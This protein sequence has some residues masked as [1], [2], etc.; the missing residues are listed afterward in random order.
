MRR[1]VAALKWPYNDTA[2]VNDHFDELTNHGQKD[3]PLDRAIEQAFAK[4][5]T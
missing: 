1:I 3:V 5:R 2:R 4:D